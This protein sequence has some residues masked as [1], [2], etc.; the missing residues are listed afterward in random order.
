MN[1]LI[2]IIIPVYN[3]EKYLEKCLDSVVNQTYKNLEIIC[4]D[5]C[6]TDSSRFILAQYAK[7]D[8]RIVIKKNNKNL[9]LGLTRNEGIKIAHGDFIHCLDSD[10]WMELNAYEIMLKHIDNETDM[11]CF[12]YT[13]HD[14]I[15]KDIL[16]VNWAEPNTF[17]EKTSIYN[18]PNSFKCWSSSTWIKLY[19]KDFIL[20]NNLYYND[21]R[22]LE[23]IEYAMRTVL[24]ARNVVFIKESLLNYRNNRKNSLLSKKNY[25]IDNIIADT[26]WA[27]QVTRELP[28][29]VR[30]IILNYIYKL[31]IENALASYNEN[32]LTFRKM[33]DAF[34]KNIDIEEF[35]N[36]FLKRIVMKVINYNHFR[37][38]C[39][40]NLRNFIR[41]YFPTFTKFWFDLK[42]GVLNAD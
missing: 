28:S 30:H 35:S 32:I 5:D 20:E 7:T 13:I 14:E 39:S 27:N 18:S 15:S 12:S 41:K 22:C 10:D 6:S 2:S 36:H 1:P 40:Y 26:I 29:E 23:D 17:Y 21:Y 25:Y 42:R 3:V 37:F 38:F 11:L 9:G 4:V 24:K 33:K 34:I 8:S 19:R 31:L 16:I